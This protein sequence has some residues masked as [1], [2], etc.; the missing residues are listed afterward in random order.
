MPILVISP[1][2]YGPLEDRA[3]LNKAEF[4]S[5]KDLERLESAPNFSESVNASGCVGVGD[6][7]AK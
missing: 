2:R 1:L 5:L 6:K 4:M 7:Q 3:P